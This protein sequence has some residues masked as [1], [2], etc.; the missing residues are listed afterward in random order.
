MAS[1]PTRAE[2][3]AILERR[4]EQ[5]SAELAGVRGEPARAVLRE[6]APDARADSP[7]ALIPAP[8]TGEESAS[9]AGGEQRVTVDV[10]GKVRRPGIAVLD[11]GARVVDA[12][13][14]A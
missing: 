14:V 3:E 7:E 11:A 6:G 10:A 5:L 4:L 9:T 13:R 1:R 8:P 12:L 2:H